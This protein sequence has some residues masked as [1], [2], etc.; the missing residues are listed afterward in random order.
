[1]AR[2]KK[3]MPRWRKLLIAGLAAATIGG[4]ALAAGNLPYFKGEKVI[5]VL[6]GDTFL[7]ESYQ[8][9]R[10]YGTD[11]PEM[12]NCMSED[13]KNALTKLILGKRVQ[14]REPISDPNRRIMALVYSGNILVNEVMIRSGFSQYIGQGQSQISRLRAASDYA[15]SNHIGI[16][17]P[18][19]YQTEP[20]NPKC[21]I[22]G[23]VDTTLHKKIYYT[24]DCPYNSKVII[25]K[26]QGDEWFCTENEA[27]N[28]GFIKSDTCD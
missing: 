26:N 17:S 3:S 14:I 15:R 2:K 7:I 13:A 22:K 25:M 12:G 1:M 21:A 4:G 28:A 27:K 10:L 9:I 11:A 5:R 19:C 8:P 20:P 18:T 24:P 23:N 16:Y 6:D